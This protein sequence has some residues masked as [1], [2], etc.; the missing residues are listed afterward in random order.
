M[1]K[2]LAQAKNSTIAQAVGLATCDERFVQLLNEAQAR[3]AD[4]GKW[5][6]TYKKLRI[7]VTAGC[8]TWPRE[9]KTIE[10]MN[11]CGY[12]IPIQNQWYEFQTDE[13]APRTGCGREGCE[14]EELLD[15]GMVTQFRDSVGSC[16]FRVYPSLTA[17]AGKRILL[18]GI[19]PATNEEIRTLDTVSGEY[20][21][22]EYVT[23]PNPAITPFVE[24]TN[25]FKQ[26]GLNGAQKPLTQGRVTIVAYNPTT[27]ISTQVAVWGPSEENPEYRRTYLIGMPEV[28]GGTSGCNAQAE[29]DCID[30]GDG[31][32]PPDEECTNTV[33][34]AIVRL[35]FIPAIVDSDWLFIG[36][37]QA[38][39][40]MMKAIQK[41][42]RNQYTEAEREIQLSLRSLRNELEAYSPN[43]RSVI[44][45]QPFGSAKTQF[46][47]GGFI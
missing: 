12:N 3:L 26:P 28:C 41:E 4:M 44:N 16:K 37:L 1:R 38:I 27:T 8:I 24:T 5:W 18:Q 15:R 32:V 6:G 21:W 40:H 2:T 11:L 45:V 14:A 36:N 7:C 46:I 20:V 35:E 22:G 17:D 23:L 19:D 43:E 10:A 13:R 29:N 34:E 31:C 30:H 9:V 33:V 47:F 25:L 42:D 39:K